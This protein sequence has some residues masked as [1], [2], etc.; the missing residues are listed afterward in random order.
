MHLNV[1][2]LYYW[3]WLSISPSFSP[4]FCFILSSSPLLIFIMSWKA[5]PIA[6][7]VNSAR[8]F[9]AGMELQ[10]L[11]S[12]RLRNACKR[13][14]LPNVYRFIQ[15]FFSHRSVLEPPLFLSSHQSKDKRYRRRYF[16]RQY[17]L[18]IEAQHPECWIVA[19]MSGWFLCSSSWGIPLRRYP[20][21]GCIKPD[22]RDKE[23]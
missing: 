9:P 8:T 13:H 17:S 22:R 5:A 18:R 6:S 3:E 4:S 2:P 1:L 23:N 11:C 10:R 12:F 7:S 16:R 14:L 15:K 20:E 21:G 19:R